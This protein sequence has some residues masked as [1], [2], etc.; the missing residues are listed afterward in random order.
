MAKVDTPSWLLGDGR[1]STV[2]IGSRIFCPPNFVCTVKCPLKLRADHKGASGQD[3]GGVTFRGMET[4]QPEVVVRTH[5]QEGEELLRGALEGDLFPQKD[6]SKRR[7]LPVRHPTLEAARVRY[8]AVTSYEEFLDS[9]VLVVTLHLVADDGA[10]QK[11]A[12]N[13]PKTQASTEV[14][15]VDLGGAPAAPDYRDYIRPSK[16]VQ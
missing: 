11:K 10:A 5:T 4:P 12:T 8:A 15:T 6:K 7:Y 2:R 9:G 13:Q 1:W 3:R 14:D 16:G